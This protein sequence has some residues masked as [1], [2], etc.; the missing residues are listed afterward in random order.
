[1]HPISLRPLIQGLLLADGKTVDALE[2]EANVTRRRAAEI[3]QGLDD[4]GLV[5]YEKDTAIIT[6]TGINFVESFRNSDWK[7]LHEIL[8]ANNAEYRTVAEILC[9]NEGPHGLTMPEICRKQNQIRLNAV[10]S[11]I[12]LE[13]GLRLGIFQKNLY[14]SGIGSRYYYVSKESETTDGFTTKLVELYNQLNIG[15]SGQR[16][17]YVSIPELRELVCEHLR[18]RRTVFDEMLRDHY[19][20]NTGKMELSG[21]PLTGTARRAPTRRLSIFADRSSV[22]MAPKIAL[23]DQEGLRFRG[24]VYQ[25]VAFLR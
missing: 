9:D 11:E 13:W 15:K 25:M 18:L 7:K 2:K 17:F 4:L 6:E 14:T 23:E 20:A 8:S 24:R 22:I 16:I 12:C 3:L 21:G 1:M 10:V 19:L 5:R